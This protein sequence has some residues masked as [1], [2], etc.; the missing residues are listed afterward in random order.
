MTKLFVS[1]FVGVGLMHASTLSAQSI[2]DTLILLDPVTA[3]A[4]RW[5]A[6]K[7]APE[8]HALDSFAVHAFALDDQRTWLAQSTGTLV[9]D[10]GP[11]QSASL[12]IRGG[13]AGHT[14]V[15][16]N[17]FPLQ[18][19]MLGQVDLSLL[20]ALIADQTFLEHG[21]YGAGWG[22]GAV[23][24]VLHLENQ[25]LPGSPK[26]NVSAQLGM[27]SNAD[28]RAQATLNIQR[29][30]WG[31]TSRAY[32]RQAENDFRFTDLSGV[33]RRREH[34][35]FNS[36][37]WLNGV[38]RYGK[39]S[40]L[41]LY[42]WLQA[43]EREIPAS[44]LQEK[45]QAAQQDQ[46]LRSIVDY[47][48]WGQQTELNLRAAWF[49]EKLDYQDPTYDYRAESLSNS[50]WLE[51]TSSWKPTRSHARIEA[52]I[53][54]G[55]F[56]AASQDYV[57]S[58][59]EGRTGLFAGLDLP[60]P[61]L[62]TRLN[63]HLRKEWNAGKPGPAIPSIQLFFREKQPLS[64]FVR[65]SR[66]YRWPTLNDRFW[67]YGA[68]PNLRPEQGW[69][70]ESGIKWSEESRT[71]NTTITLNGYIRNMSDWI[72]WVPGAD[73]IWRPQNIQYVRSRGLE[74]VLRN[75]R[76]LGKGKIW[77]ETRLDIVRA[78]TE[79]STQ[80][81]DPALGKQLVYVPLFKNA[82]QVGFTTR[83]WEAAYRH[84]WTSEV[85]TTADH[86]TELPALHLGQI[87]IRW[88]QHKRWA[89]DLSCSIRNL[90]NTHYQSV[91]LWPMPGRHVLVQL[92]WK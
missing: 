90:W 18:H 50:V 42:N 73:Q 15:Q 35:Q 66:T 92:S 5:H 39:Q 55:I 52:G 1:I 85:F 81:A 32:H 23:G 29:A 53:Q 21:V 71:W 69:G 58:V 28:Y 65:A 19:P 72:Q 70:A 77:L 9:K 60:F 13:S 56:H 64:Y 24:G 80:A 54:Q 78:R 51:A 61:S 88:K 91:A 22:S 47:K 30:H 46:T 83:S 17:G 44:L 62:A 79:K 34:A 74:A 86:S 67:A 16:W 11:G 63:L 33:S 57:A 45:S 3:T 49:R 27:G 36:S 41:S 31:L 25:M 76:P 89:P 10:Y 7:K 43:S 40:K 87:D 75:E 20:P 4:T 38:S 84:T 2:P 48:K 59:S 8:V 14:A 37:G 82:T 26:T 6:V 68:N 12:S